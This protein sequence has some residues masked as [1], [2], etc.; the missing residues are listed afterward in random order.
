MC[1]CNV[2]QPHQYRNALTIAYNGSWPLLTK[3][4]PYVFAA[5]DDV[6]VCIPRRK[7]RLSTLLYAQFMLNREVWRHSYGRKCFR[8]KLKRFNI[9][10]PI[11]DN[12][13]LNEQAIE[14]IVACASYW[15]FYEELVSKLEATEKTGTM[16]P[17][18]NEENPPQN[19]API[20]TK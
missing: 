13:D 8:E 14:N 4:H 2:P 16:E 9:E 11:D 15:K 18:L 5:K 7:F 1:Y 3:Y 20:L 19:I 6:A 17:F 12:G 10:V